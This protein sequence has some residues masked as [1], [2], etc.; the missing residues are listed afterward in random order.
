[1]TETKRRANRNVVGLGFV[2]NTQDVPD[3]AVAACEL[4]MACC[5]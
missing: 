5:S 4:C 1:M 3:E 2:P